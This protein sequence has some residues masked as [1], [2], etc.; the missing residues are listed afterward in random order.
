MKILRYRSLKEEYTSPDLKLIESSFSTPNDLITWY[1][2]LR[3]YNKYRSIFGKYAGAQKD[4]LDEDTDKYI[5]L[6][7]QFLS[8]FNCKMTDFQIMACKELVRAGGGELHNIASFIGG[9]AAQEAI[10]EF[11][12]SLFTFK[13]T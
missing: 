3:S 12:K 9:V 10:K 6:T 8:K 2:A 5:H 13:I 7:E 1:I 11:K 4:T